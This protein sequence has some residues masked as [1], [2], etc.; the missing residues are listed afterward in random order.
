MPQGLTS[1]GAFLYVSSYRPTPDLK[2]NTGPCRV[3]RIEK[4]SGR[5]TGSFDIPA[6][7]CTHSGGLAY[8]NDP[9]VRRPPR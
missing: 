9:T 7:T 5:I 4:A 1:S 8:F 3:F 2:A 6:G